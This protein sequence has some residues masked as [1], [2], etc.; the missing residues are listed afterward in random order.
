MTDYR[1]PSRPLPM[2]GLYLWLE[3]VQQRLKLSLCAGTS[4]D[5]TGTKSPREEKNKSHSVYMLTGPEAGRLENHP[6]DGSCKFGCTQYH[7]KETPP[8][9]VAAIPD[10]V[11]VL[12]T[13]A[14]QTVRRCHCEPP[15]LYVVL[16]RVLMKMNKMRPR[17]KRE[18]H[19][20]PH[21]PGR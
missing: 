1:Y 8:R 20:R 5:N 4:V 11:V 7:T 9:S 15:K 16:A 3:N 2:Y 12:T 17:Q 13:P 21:S 19:P 18:E 6:K 10:G 14:E